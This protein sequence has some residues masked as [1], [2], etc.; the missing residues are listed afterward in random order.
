MSVD[1]EIFMASFDFKGDCA[2]QILELLR[3]AYPGVELPQRVSGEHR[4]CHLPQPY[5][6]LAA[7]VAYFH[8]NDEDKFA[9]L[10]VSKIF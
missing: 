10:L 4:I 2:D 3:E 1:G 6:G 9:P 8:H 7:E 5:V